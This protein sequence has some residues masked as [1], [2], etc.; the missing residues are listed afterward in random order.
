[1]LTFIHASDFHL[2]APFSALSPQQA[3]Q[4]RGEQRALLE[5]LAD[6]VEQ[7]GAQ[8]L[9][10]P[11]D[12]LDG[13]RVYYETTQTLA[14]TLAGMRAR[15]FIAPG[16][17]DF[18]SPRSPW[19]MVDWS[20]NVHIFRSTE[21]E[22][23]PLPHL[24]CTV[25]GSAFTAPA[26]DDSP[27]AN[28]SAPRDGGIHLMCVHGDVDGKGRYASITPAQIAD[29]GLTYL[30][31]GHIHGGTGLRRTGETYWAY[32]GCPEG[33]GFDELGDKGVLLGKI[34][35][36]RLSLDFVPLAG[37]KYEILSVDVSGD[38]PAQALESAL[39]K[40]AQQ[41]IYRIILTGE[42]DPAGLDLAALEAV[43]APFFYSVSL[44]DQTRVRRDLWGRAQEDSLTGLFLREMQAKL[45]AAGEEG[46]GETVEMA[47]RF[48]LAAL[49]DREDCYL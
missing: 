27:L 16:N 24:G 14:R 32:P 44:R 9:L 15:V 5:R 37:H 38:D 8:I 12:L 13:D 36:D 49:E 46:L 48:G 17:H 22:S 11:G 28:F 33:R 35:G 1:M 10:L 41:D 40:N 25:Y 45:A 6:L 26:R 2:D 3:A 30:A 42:C 47:V 39:P 18:W 23:V 4:R 43:A 29:S 31:L 34:E 19:A 7:T 20:E 21:V